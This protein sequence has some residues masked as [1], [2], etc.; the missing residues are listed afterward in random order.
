MT[1]EDQVFAIHMKDHWTEEDIRFLNAHSEVSIYPKMD[2]K[3][4]EELNRRAQEKYEA[5]LRQEEA[6]RER[7]EEY[8]AK[9]KK[10]LAEGL[11]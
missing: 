10:M 8:R 2:P 3:A 1:I 9:R 7:L 6:A 4:K 11:A 5:K